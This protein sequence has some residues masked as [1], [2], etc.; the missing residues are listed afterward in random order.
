MNIQKPLALLTLRIR[1]PGR[2]WLLFLQLAPGT[3]Q[4]PLNSNILPPVLNNPN[5]L[6]IS[7]STMPGV[8]DFIIKSD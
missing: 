1:S 4:L 6:V 7:Q 5:S 3:L 2:V 8:K